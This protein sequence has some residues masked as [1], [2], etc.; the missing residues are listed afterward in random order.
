M[1]QRAFQALNSYKWSLA[2]QNIGGDLN[3]KQNSNE[4]VES[5]NLNRWNIKKIP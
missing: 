1:D 2:K 4:E 3:M 5:K